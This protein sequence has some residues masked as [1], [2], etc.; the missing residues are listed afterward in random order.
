MSSNGIQPPGDVS[1]LFRPKRRLWASAWVAW[2]AFTTPIFLAAYLL[3]AGRGHWLPVVATH[4]LLMIAFVLAAGRLKG[5]GVLMSA[6]GIRE[7]EYFSRAV[8]TPVE[9]IA[10]VLVVRLRDANSD[11]VSKQAFV[12]DAAG[13]TLLR[14]RS[15]LWHA[16]DFA[17]MV[18]FYGVPVTA[19][20]TELTW[21]QLRRTYP[22]NLEPW[23]RHPVLTA[24]VCGV[25]IIALAFVTVTAFMLGGA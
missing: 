8:F 19:C 2:L 18:E 5:A 21:P 15:P 17:N 22:G 14:L 24:I 11:E 9:Q 3:T 12:T 13:R 10:E 7:R 25:A 6:D 20:E 16:R 23:E 1:R 4:A